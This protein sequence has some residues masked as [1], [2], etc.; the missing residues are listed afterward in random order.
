MRHKLDLIG[1]HRVN[2]TS[3]ELFET[4]E[5]VGFEGGGVLIVSRIR[6]CG[7]PLIHQ[8]IAALLLQLGVGWAWRRCWIVFAQ[9]VLEGDRGWLVACQT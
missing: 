2:R 9:E 4:D 7:A 3:V 5:S 6:G 1:S 8:E